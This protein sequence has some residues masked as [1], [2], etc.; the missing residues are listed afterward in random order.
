MR[1]KLEDAIKRYGLSHMHADIV[2]MVFPTIMVKPERQE[3]IPEG[4]S[5]MGGFPDFPKDWEYPTYKDIPLQFIA[6]LN[7]TELAV[8]S[9]ASVLPHKGMLY[10][11]YLEDAGDDIVWGEPHQKDGWRVLYFDGDVSELQTVQGASHVY[12]Q[13]ALSFWEEER[14]QELFIED[15]ADSDKYY[16]MVEELYPETYDYHQIL[17]YPRALQNE[18]FEEIADMTEKRQD[19]YV[20]LLQVDSDEQNLNMLWGDSGML[21][22]CITKEDLANERFENSWL[23]MQCL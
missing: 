11:F 1:Q 10:F 19:E 13:C 5:K 22:Y 21:Y 18:V 6:Q 17:G 4:Q 2:N 12:P 7:L 23:L 16:A 3:M 8:F 14:L 9:Q 20:L 15:E